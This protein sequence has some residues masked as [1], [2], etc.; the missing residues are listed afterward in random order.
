M[1][2]DPYTLVIA[3]DSNGEASGELCLDDG[4][5]YGFKSGSFTLMKFTYSYR[6]GIQAEVVAGGEKSFVGWRNKVERIAISGLDFGAIKSVA[7]ESGKSADRVI[8]VEYLTDCNVAIFRKPDMEVGTN[9][10]LNIYVQQIINA[11][12]K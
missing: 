9:W 3:P 7:I 11:I 8:A 1:I 2:H 6:S 5:S 4:K 10:K 12:A